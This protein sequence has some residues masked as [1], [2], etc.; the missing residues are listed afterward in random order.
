[1]RALK[2]IN[3]SKFL[4]SKNTT[5]T[6]F[7]WLNQ[8]LTG[9]MMF[10]LM[11]YYF[12]TFNSDKYTSY[13][14]ILGVI[15]FFALLE[16]GLGNSIQNFVSKYLD[17]ENILREFITASF[18]IILIL[19]PIV[20]CL[21]LIFSKPIYSSIL[22]FNTVDYLFAFQILGII[23]ISNSFFS[24]SNKVYFS[25]Y[26]GYKVQIASISSTSI[27]AFCIFLLN[28]LDM[29][30]EY[31]LCFQY[32][33]I[34][35]FSFYFSLRLFKKYKVHNSIFK[36]NQYII[37]FKNVMFKFFF[38][39]LFSLLTLQVDYL[40]AS[41]TIIN[42]DI[43][44][45]NFISKFYIL[46]FSLYGTSLAVIWPVFSELLNKNQWQKVDNY[47]KRI[48]K[49]G[50]SYILLFSIVFFLFRN[51]FLD[52][53]LPNNKISIDYIDLLPFSIL[54]LIRIWTDIYA[55]ALQSFNKLNIF[56]IYMPIQAI[57][58]V[59]SQIYLTR[60][61]GYLGI[62]YGIILSFLLTASWVVYLE[63][64]KIKGEKKT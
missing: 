6:I 35:F 9:L 17:D 12:T 55:V 21:F 24:F 56:I 11:R 8:L 45:Y 51:F 53:L 23:L 27:Y 26:Q 5:T 38:F 30:L 46:A 25:L 10:F 7:S 29:K 39:S 34:L 14:I 13:L 28:K 22:N 54:Y 33:P 60:Y 16:L 4:N 63:F 31:Y 18:Q 50:F 37:Q 58:S 43:I 41:H 59:F 64:N 40:V 62:P 15:P 20:I 44:K 49:F 57:I 1:M 47:I 36:K 2:L 19:L 32:F 3:V 61:F 52:I 42:N 48:I